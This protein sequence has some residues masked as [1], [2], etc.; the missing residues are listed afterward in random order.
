[1][2]QTVSD[3]P[4]GILEMPADRPKSCNKFNKTAFQII[5][6][7]IITGAIIT[8]IYLFLLV[9]IKKSS[10]PG[11]SIISLKCYHLDGCTHN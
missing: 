1:M 6:Y 8:A 5:N 3:N 4:N 11:Y 2:I 10:L 9:L 7:N